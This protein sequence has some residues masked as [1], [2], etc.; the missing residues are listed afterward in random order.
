[1][2]LESNQGAN[3]TLINTSPSQLRQL[4]GNLSPTTTSQDRVSYKNLSFKLFCFRL[5]ANHHLTLK[6]ISRHTVTY[7][8]CQSRIS[9]L[10]FK[11]GIPMWKSAMTR[12]LCGTNYPYSNKSSKNRNT[13]NGSDK[14]LT[15]LKFFRN[16]TSSH[17]KRNLKIN[18]SNSSNQ[19]HTVK[20]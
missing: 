8:G 13:N 3:S 10:P 15:M 9:S 19:K 14:K 7:T 16:L 11:I 17:N 12:S 6:V 2:T 1:L 4:R 20:Q 18:K 5:N